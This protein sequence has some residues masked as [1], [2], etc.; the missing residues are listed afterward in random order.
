MYEMPYIEFFNRGKASKR[1]FRPESL[2]KWKTTI[3]ISVKK[4]KLATVN[5][6]TRTH[7]AKIRIPLCGI[8]RLTDAAFSVL[9]SRADIYNPADTIE[10]VKVD[11]KAV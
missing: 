2:N 11:K 5:A 7:H 4:E 3:K 10:N 6:T 1:P 9:Q 8:Q